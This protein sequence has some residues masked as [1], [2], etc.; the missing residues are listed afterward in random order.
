MVITKTTNLR[1]FDVVIKKMSR[2]L[3]DLKAFGD[4][5][6]TWLH[7]NH[8]Y[9]VPLP[10]LTN[11]N[12]QERDNDEHNIEMG[13][14]ARFSSSLCFYSLTCFIFGIW[15]LLCSNYNFI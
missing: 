13:D 10:N 11:D 8:G 7:D 5:G 6:P 2:R 12:A 9:G 14:F 15:M 4:R 1:L 3:V